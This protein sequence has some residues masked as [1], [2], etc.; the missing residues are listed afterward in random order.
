MSESNDAR[1]T[2]EVEHVSI[3]EYTEEAANYDRVPGEKIIVGGI[4]RNQ[5][6]RDEEKE[7]FVQVADGVAVIELHQPIPEEDVTEWCNSQAGKLALSHWFDHNEPE[8]IVTT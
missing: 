8:E 5:H 3:L 4:R 2:G 1:S 7:G 6:F